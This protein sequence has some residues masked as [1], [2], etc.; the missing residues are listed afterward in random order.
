M[1]TAIDRV[2]EDA[3]KLPAEVELDE[4]VRYY[5]DCQLGLGI[6]FS[7]DGYS[8]IQRACKYPEA[9]AVMSQ[10]TRRCLVNRFPFGVTFQIKSGM[11]QIVAVANLHR[12]PGY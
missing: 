12:R 7:E 2:I 11:L 5:E 9:W 1:A 3:L 8:A 6:D 10:N 4:A